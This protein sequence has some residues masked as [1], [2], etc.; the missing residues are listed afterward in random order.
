VACIEE[1]AWR[2][3]WISTEALKQLG[4]EMKTQYGRYLE[5][6]ASK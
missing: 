1:I 5:R 3:G 2:N 6:L 4:S